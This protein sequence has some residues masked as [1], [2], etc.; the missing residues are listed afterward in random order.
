[1][2]GCVPF[3]AGEG[4]D[5]V[6]EGLGDIQDVA[7]NSIYNVELAANALR[8]F[9]H[10]LDP[11][12]VDIAL[13]N[14]GALSNPFDIGEPPTLT[15]VTFN[16]PVK[17]YDFE[18]NVP[19]F[20]Q[21]A[22]P[23][24]EFTTLPP[25]L[26]LPNSPTPL[27]AE[28]P[29]NP[30]E[31]GNYAFPSAPTDP[32]PPLPALFPLEVPSVPAIADLSFDW[33]EPAELEDLRAGTF[34]WSDT[35]YTP[36]VRQE[37]VD[38]I[39]AILGGSTGIPDVIW[40]MI[41]ERARAQARQVARQVEE[42]A[43][44]LWAGKGHFLSNGAQRKRVKEA[45]DVERETV[46]AQI[47]EL[48]IQDAK[49]YVERLNTA[50]AQGIALE[51]QLIGLYNAQMDR[52]LLAA[53]TVFEL[54]VAAANLRIAQYNA[55]M[56]AFLQ[57]AQVLKIQLEAEILKLERIKVIL[58]AQQLRGQLNL[59]LLESYKAQIQALVA[60]YGIFESE[61]KGVIAKYDADKTRVAAFGELVTVYQTQQ[62][63]KETEW[64]G[65]GEAVKA[66]NLQFDGYDTL[67]K[68]FLT[69]AQIYST[70]VEADKSVFQ[71]YVER[72]KLR[73]ERLNLAIQELG[74]NVQAES[75]EVDAG[76]KIQELGARIFEALGNVERSRIESD[77]QRFNVLVQN[78]NF[79]MQAQVQ[80][81][82][83]KLQDAK[84]IMDAQI[85]GLG[86]ILQGHASI[87][88]SA[89]AALNFTA[90]VQNTT[91]NQFT[92]TNHY[93]FAGG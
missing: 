55:R 17:D 71:A 29:S 13:E 78:A 30:P 86:A 32:I 50:L 92:C 26:N 74:I 75:A 7:E 40:N 5:L 76:I 16:K 21:T 43:A 60:R 9:V 62:Q 83:M 88:S 89:L 23:P 4:L 45:L 8:S 19:D 79:K 14:A 56:A 53:R 24:G 58:E 82:Q 84:N 20:N 66:E 67:A 87:G 12:D 80:E 48:V 39:K 36:T 41:E 6:V 10:T 69:K 3:G 2:A 18:L 77:A 93:E 46:S 37:V 64:R 25:E 73:M 44:D 33:P 68:A 59:Q 28:A 49:I 63:A 38:Q 35:G 65:Y 57:R 54:I 31:V 34:E 27:A 22:V 70:G 72:E 1:M 61:I 47:R 90:A 85:Q 15:P 91:D 51:Q 81:T 11:L 42:D 52:S